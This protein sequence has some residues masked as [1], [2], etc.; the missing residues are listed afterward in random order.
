MSPDNIENAGPGKVR[1]PGKAT[2]PV[3]VSDDQLAAEVYELICRHGIHRVLEAL[4]A[5]DG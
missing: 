5:L 3:T 2:R 1:Y 4:K